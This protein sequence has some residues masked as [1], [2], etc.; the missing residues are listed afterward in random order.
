[1]N[2]IVSVCA[3]RSR[4]TF[5]LFDVVAGICIVLLIGLAGIGSSKSAAAGG[6]GGARELTL[7]LIDGEQ[8]WA[9]V[10]SQADLMPV[11]RG[12][13]YAFDFYGDTAGNQGQPLL[14]SSAGRY[15]WSE[16]AFAFRFDG[17]RLTASSRLAPIES[18]RSGDSLKEVYRYVSRRF[19]PPS[20][21][22]PD[23]ILFSRPQFNTWIELTYNQNQ[24]DILDYAGKAVDAGFPPGVLMIDEGWARD[25]GDWTFDGGR[26]EDPKEMIR[27]LHDL[28][29]KVMLW[30]CPYIT[31]DGPFYSA[32]QRQSNREGSNVW[33]INPKKPQLPAIMQW[34]DGFSAMVDLTNPSGKRWLKDQLDHLVSDYG[35]DGFKFDGGDAVHYSAQRMLTPFESYRPGIT[36]NEHSEEFARL[37]LDYPLNEYRACWKMGGQPL[38]QRLRDKR[39]NWDD[40]RKLIP[41]IIDQGLMGYPFSCPDMIGGGEYLS[42][43]DL[44]Q[45]DQELI[46]RAAECHALMPMMQFSVA[47]WRVLDR[48]NLGYCLD[49]ARLHAKMGDEILGLAREAARTGEPIVRSLEYE[50]PHQGY[51]GVDDEFL[52][53]RTIL[54]APVLEK[55]ARKRTIVFPSGLWEAE[56]GSEV[57]GPRTLE[58]EAPLGR[59]PWYRRSG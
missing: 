17:Q 6:E 55:G 27:N 54:V 19:F 10:I 5:P 7:D 47:P 22:I 41:G 43:I 57:R 56:D 35:V 45:V 23:P 9:G 21:R 40:L 24:R 16:S 32:L 39:H 20:G 14:I 15:V 51:V 25:Y 2:R 58:V 37:G 4:G 12:S 59:L 26:F 30:V 48:Q 8:W 1:M 50:F 33:I 38:A 36:P 28:G 34:W 31:S 44:K 46:V 49:M 42:F 52:L 11:G 13:D 53:G 18:G 29:F 3:R